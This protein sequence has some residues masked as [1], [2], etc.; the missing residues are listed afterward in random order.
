[1]V[2][3][4]A[5]T[6]DYESHATHGGGN[7]L[8]RRTIYDSCRA[9][10]EMNPELLVDTSEIAQRLRLE[11]SHTVNNSRYRD[12]QSPVKSHAI[13]LENLASGLM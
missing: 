3:E 10:P 4:S 11:L 5:S 6:E 12:D 9:K 1:M 8:E 7:R 2:A 13:P